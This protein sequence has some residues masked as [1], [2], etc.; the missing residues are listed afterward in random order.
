[1]RNTDA[2]RERE[3]EICTVA[4][5]WVLMH[6]GLVNVRMLVRLIS[7][8]EYYVVGGFIHCIVA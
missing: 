4:A 1:M 3:T 2:K 6:G 5:S 8:L 7:G